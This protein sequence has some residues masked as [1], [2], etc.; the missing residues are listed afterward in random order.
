MNKIP[1]IDPNE[2]FQ[3]SYKIDEQGWVMRENLDFVFRVYFPGDA[4]WLSEMPD[5][6]DQLGAA[7]GLSLDS[8]Q[9]PDEMFEKCG[10]TEIEQE[11][12]E[13]Y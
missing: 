8:G 12:N 6:D 9:D 3:N 11:K 4:E 10:L 5:F 13:D 2:Y 7:Y 1:K